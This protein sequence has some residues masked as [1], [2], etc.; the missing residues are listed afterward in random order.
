MQQT[1]GATLDAGA[2]VV[3]NT[4]GTDLIATNNDTG[5]VAVY[6]PGDIA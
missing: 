5:I 2:G 3:I 6:D 1:T 4:N